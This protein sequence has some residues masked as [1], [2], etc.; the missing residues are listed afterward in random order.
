MICMII[1]RNVIKFIILINIFIYFIIGLN[2]SPKF[3]ARSPSHHPGCVQGN[4]RRKSRFTPGRIKLIN[5]DTDP[6][7]NGREAPTVQAQGK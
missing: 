7:Y 2:R 5:P 3:L 4:T 6:G 1:F